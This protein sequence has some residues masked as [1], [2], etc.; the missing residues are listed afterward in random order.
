MDFDIA[1][2]IS[3]GGFS[4]IPGKFQPTYQDIQGIADESLKNKHGSIFTFNANEFSLEFLYDSN[5]DYIGD[6]IEFH[7]SQCEIFS[8]KVSMQDVKELPLCEFPKPSA[9]Y[10]GIF[11]EAYYDE[12][13]LILFARSGAN[14]HFKKMIANGKEVYLLNKITSNN[15]YNVSARL[16]IKNNM[17]LKALEN[18]HII[19][20]P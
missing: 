15:I 11:E 1:D 9:K 6:Q 8:D 10:K 4:F 13:E 5:Y 7:P 12:N 20:W 2:Y 16:M 3:Y 14:V 17:A 18:I 19:A